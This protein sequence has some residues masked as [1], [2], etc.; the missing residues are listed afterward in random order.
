MYPEEG[1]SGQD[2]IILC[3]SRGR[4]GGD[5]DAADGAGGGV[6]GVVVEGSRGGEL[7]GDDSGTG[8]RPED[9]GVA[10]GGDEEAGRLREGVGRLSAPSRML[11]PQSRAKHG[12]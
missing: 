7:V 5:E 6:A 9:R 10:E 12:T 2:N 8:D 4:G 3:L 1:L 11:V